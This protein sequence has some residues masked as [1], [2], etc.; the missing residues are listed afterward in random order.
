MMRA[1]F[2]LVLILILGSAGNGFAVPLESMPGPAVQGNDSPTVTSAIATSSPVL[3]TTSPAVSSSSV[4]AGD[5]LVG[6]GGADSGAPKIPKFPVE[7]FVRRG[8]S[9]RFELFFLNVKYGYDLQDFQFYKAWCLDKG[10]PLP[11]GTVHNVR[12]YNSSDPNMPPS[13]KRLQWRQINYVINHKVGSKEDVQEAIWHLSKDRGH[14]KMSAKAVRMI[15]E[16][17]LKGKDY[18][19][20]AGDLVAIL[21][22]SVGNQ[23]PVFI[24]Y[25]LPQ[26][27]PAAVKA[28]IFPAPL[29]ASVGGF[30]SRLFIPPFFFWPGGGGG[31]SVPHT[32]VPEPS[33]LLLLA[34]GMICLLLLS[35]K[36]EK[37]L[38]CRP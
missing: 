7:M 32:P 36:V 25:K 26:R 20:A 17:S 28:A 13:F 14:G 24:E 16:A 27:R 9:S 21:C 19:P 30:A 29:P 37:R 3:A 34:A 10:A 4:P 12:L 38:Q 23:Q 1:S 15:H 11:G 22:Q 18:N 31:S 5:P 8:T 35:R 6:A 2:F 33:S